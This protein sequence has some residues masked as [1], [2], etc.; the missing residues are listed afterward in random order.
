MI[1][2]P[3]QPT[4]PK[5]AFAF[6]RPGFP[7]ESIAATEPVPAQIVGVLDGLPASRVTGSAPSFMPHVPA[8]AIDN[9]RRARPLLY[10]DQAE[11]TGAEFDEV[12]RGL[13]RQKIFIADPELHNILDALHRAY[14]GM[15]R[16]PI[17]KAKL[18]LTSPIWLLAALN[19][20]D[21]G[22]NLTLKDLRGFLPPQFKN[23][24]HPVRQMVKA[25]VLDRISN[26][27]YR[28]TDRMV[29]LDSLAG[30]AVARS[31]A[32]KGGP[33]CDRQDLSL[34]RVR[35]RQTSVDEIG[36]AGDIRGFVAGQER[37][38]AGDLFGPAQAAERNLLLQRD[39]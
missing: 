19:K 10:N 30:M 38:Q 18:N 4:V 29:A 21:H 32:P 17:V 14:A 7:I 6:F 27:H 34:L 1:N 36:A 39:Q 28:R 37:N 5:P 8:M 25:G 13:A 33:P 2:E 31:R 16:P 24:M 3:R 23:L 20:I 35:H 26:G 12:K 11:P 9:V 22:E 15:P